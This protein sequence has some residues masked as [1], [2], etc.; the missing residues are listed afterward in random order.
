M[1][2]LHTY[3]ARLVIYVGL[4]LAF[5]LGV[6]S[7]SYYSSRG[8][9]R[10]EAERNV[11][12]VAQQIEG[13]MAREARDL[14]ERVKMVRDN[15]SLVEYIH[16]VLWLGTDGGAVRE[17]YQRQF[18]W[19]PVH[20]VVLLAPDGRPLL[21]GEHA[22]LA[23]RL[24]A[25]NRGDPPDGHFYFRGA[26]GLELVAYATV[27]Y[28]SQVLGIAAITRAIDRAWLL[29]AREAGGGQLFLV[30]DGRIALGTGDASF[31]GLGF[32]PAGNA[33]TLRDEGYLVRPIA[34][35]ASPAALPTLWFGLSDAELLRQLTEQRN[36]ILG[37]AIAG[38]LGILLVGFML[39]RNF[40]A[41]LTRLV[42]VMQAVSEGRF[43]EVGETSARDE[44]GYLLNRFSAMVASLR[45]K[46]EEI[47]RVH[48][49][50]AEQA[51]TD[52]LTGFYNRRY[53]YELYPKLWS[54]A[55]RSDQ[56]LV[57]LLIDLDLFKQINDRHGHM[58]GDEVLRHFARA[59]RD[60]CRV[61]DFVFR[62]GGEEF[63]VLNHGDLDGAQVQAEKIRAAVERVA[64]TH[65]KGSIRVTASIG[66]ARAE[67]VDGLNSL[68]AVLRRADTA[69]YAA[70]QAGRN[71]VAVAEA[72][73]C[74]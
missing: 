23:A 26:R 52:A 17:L 53:L 48:T 64:V 46:Q 12:R 6:L 30:E 44:F 5:L 41:P 66:V 35:A 1:F 57:V 14:L 47:R 68:S 34:F 43:P 50:L 55:L 25:L 60:S 11:A 63:L 20:R 40:S 65:E 59:L 72:P 54:E 69:L 70:K 37:L 42:G 56:H 74:A 62:M 67:R 28:R 24:S 58:A 4:L 61:S 36:V 45:E 16:V 18:G 51:T 3:R 32:A 9:I 22:D 49:Q 39:L 8:V 33:I 10:G 19:L 27:R 38:S 71:R 7:F 31:T 15:S 13:Q 2:G 21:G 29:A 73:A